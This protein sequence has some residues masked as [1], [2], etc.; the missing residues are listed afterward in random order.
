M[1]NRIQHQH[2]RHP[3]VP[4]AFVESTLAAATR[5]THGEAHRRAAAK[6]QRNAMHLMRRGE[7]NAEPYADGEVA[8]FTDAFRLA[9]GL[10][11]A[12]TVHLSPVDLADFARH[13]SVTDWLEYA[14]SIGLD[15]ASLATR[16]L[17]VLL[18]EHHSGIR[19]VA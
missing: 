13:M 5:E 4:Q 9:R 6:A 1:K 10:Q 8:S 16:E 19:G 11:I 3:E 15:G 17:T 18:L 12:A 14:R 2:R 7:L